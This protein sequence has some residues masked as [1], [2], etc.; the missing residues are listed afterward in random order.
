MS[1]AVVPNHVRDFAGSKG[2]STK[3]VPGI[4]REALGLASLEG[5]SYLQGK[6]LTSYYV[7]P[8]ER[9]GA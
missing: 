5:G 6:L 4:R 7:K 2:I 3:K 9:T 1:P 8:R